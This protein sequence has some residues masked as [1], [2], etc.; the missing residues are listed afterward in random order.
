M[1]Q[2]IFQN[3]YKAF[4]E[5]DAETI[6][7]NPMIV[8]DKNEV[9]ALDAKMNFDENALFRQKEIAAMRDETEEDENEREAKNWDLSYVSM[10]GN[11]GCMVNGAGLGDGNDGYH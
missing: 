7:I 2:F 4:V 11:I 8:T 1:R 5:L 3:L 10:D 9:M 6:E